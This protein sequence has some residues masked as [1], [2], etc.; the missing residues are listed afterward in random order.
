MNWAS[1]RVL[2]CR[3]LSWILPR[4][5]QETEEGL[6]GWKNS[7]TNKTLSPAWSAVLFEAGTFGGPSTLSGTSPRGRAYPFYTFYTIYTIYTIF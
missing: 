4:S 6:F 5:G 1:P 2:A 7:K 3:R